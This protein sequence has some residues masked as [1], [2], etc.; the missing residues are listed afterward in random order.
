MLL[1]RC[2]SSVFFS[3]TL[4]TLDAAG[5][6]LDVACAT[7]DTGC[8]TLLDAAGKTLMVLFNFFFFFILFFFLFCFFIAFV[9][10]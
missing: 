1:A 5:A 8:V 7:L 3:S 4:L 2:F 10:F 9:S 6:T